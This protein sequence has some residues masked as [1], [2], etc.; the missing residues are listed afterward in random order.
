MPIEKVGEMIEF[1]CNNYSFSTCR[2]DFV[3]GGEPLW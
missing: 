3:G 2:V 1:F